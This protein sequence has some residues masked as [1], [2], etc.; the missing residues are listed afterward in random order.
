MILTCPQCATRYFLPDAQVGR[1]GRAVKCTNCG[2][3]WRAGGAPEPEPQPEPEPVFEAPSHHFDAK[4]CSTPAQGGGFQRLMASALGLGQQKIVNKVYEGAI[5]RMRTDAEKEAQAEASERIAAAQAEQNAKLRQFLPGD[6]SLNIKDVTIAGLSLRST[7]ANALVGG[8]LKWANDPAS[9]G[10]DVPQPPR[11]SQPASGVSADIHFTSVASNLISGFLNSPMATGVENLTIETRKVEP[12]M[13]PGDALKIS[14]NIDFPSYIKKLDETN[15]QNSPDRQVIRI[16]KP[17]A[18]PEIAADA[19]GHLVVIAHDLQFDLPVPPAVAKSGLGS[20]AKVY[21]LVAPSAE[22]VFEIKPVTAPD[23]SIRLTGNLKD[24]SPGPGSKVYAI[25][26]NE[27]KALPLDPFRSVFIFQGFA[28][29]IRSKPLD[30][31]LEN[32]K[33]RG[34]QITSISDLD[35]SGWMR[36]VLTPT[37]ENPLAAAGGG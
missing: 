8:T 4:I 33:L 19:D 32:I 12:G 20:P 14:K 31:P 2:Q 27:A 15:A 35:P 16:K 37:G 26:D 18:A 29:A 30:I 23:G 25:N 13:A 1:E 5:G 10:A 21:R 7:P 6:G 9:G 28:A 3:V 11:F 34:Y 36:I 17:K 22:F 24:F